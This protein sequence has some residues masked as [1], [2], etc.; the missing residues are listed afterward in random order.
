MAVSRVVGHVSGQPVVEPRPSSER[1]AHRR[2]ET[3]CC[4]SGKVP[5]GSLMGRPHGEPGDRVPERPTQ[6]QPGRAGPARGP[7][8]VMIELRSADVGVGVT[9]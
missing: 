2:R 9:S 5:V 4:T 1:E 7:Y 3:S 8:T 6:G